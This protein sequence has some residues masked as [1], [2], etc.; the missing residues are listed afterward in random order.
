METK[1]GLDFPVIKKIRAVFSGF[2]QIE[3]V[4]LY[5]SRA[6]GNFRPGSDIDLT[7]MG[8]QLTM[9]QLIQIENELDDLSL[10]YKIDLSLLHAIESKDLIDHIHRIGIMF[11]ENR[12]QTTV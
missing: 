12:G 6:K 4:L 7:L 1:I 2:P 8:E 5:G 11:Y 9:S 10:P 3:Q